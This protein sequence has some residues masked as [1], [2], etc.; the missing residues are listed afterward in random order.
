VPIPTPFRYANFINTELLEPIAAGDTTIRIPVSVSQALPTL[1]VP[2]KIMLALWDGQQAP[3]LIGVTDNPQSGFMTVERA[4]ESTSGVAWD[5]GTQVKCVLSAGIIDAALQAYFDLPGQLTGFYLPL[6]GGTLTGPLFLPL[7][8]NPVTN[9]AVT[10][11]YVDVVSAGYMKADGSI[12]MTG[13]LVMSNNTIVGL[14]VPT[15]PTGAATKDYVDNKVAAGGGG[16]GGGSGSAY[17]DDS[18]GEITTGTGAA[19]VIPIVTDHAGVFTNVSLTFRPHVDSERGCTLTVQKA[20][21]TVLAAKPIWMKANKDPSYRMLQAG[22]PYRVT[23]N[24]TAWVLHNMASMVTEVDTGQIVWEPKAGAAAKTG[25]VRLHGG[26]IGLTAGSEGF[27]A[28][29]KDLYIYNWG[30][31]DNTLC[32][33]SGGRGLDASAD[34]AANKTLTLLDARG[35]GPHGTDTTV[36]PAGKITA[37]N[38]LVGAPDKAGSSGG[39]EKHQIAAANLPTGGITSTATVTNGTVPFVGSADGGLVGVDR[40]NSGGSGQKDSA[41]VILG[42]SSTASGGNPNMNVGTK[43]VGVTVASSFTGAANTPLP[44]MSPFM[45]GTFYQRM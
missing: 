43:N 23:Y 44:D 42:G 37:A 7:E 29:F 18:Y 24:G 33:V 35:K 8:A 10:K 41:Y 45:L 36:S 13:N 39:N 28:A 4:M 40:Y 9:Q 20:G 3:E 32:A 6:S 21:V 31:F 2:E 26:T 27:G 22:T 14:G 30:N 15:L 11:G 38:I 16:G 1:V 5:A 12:P 25:Y 17:A 34:W 19:Y